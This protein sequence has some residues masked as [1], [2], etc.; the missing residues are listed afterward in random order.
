MCV[1]IFG[2]WIAAT[3]L[4]VAAFAVADD[5][6]DG[7]Y[8]ND[9]SA[10]SFESFE[11]SGVDPAANG[12]GN[13]SYL[14]PLLAGFYPDPS[15]CR[16]GGDYYL[17]NSTFA[18]FPGIPIFHSTDLVNW[19]QLGHVIDR[20]E[21][22][23]Y[24]WVGVSGGIFAP[25][26][27]HHDGTFYVVCTMVGGEGNFVVTATDSAGPWSDATPLRFEG[28]D[29][30]LFFDDDG[31]AWIVNNGAPEGRP[32][33]EGH[34][35]IWL[36]EF[37][38]VAKR[39]VGPRKVLVNGGVD[40]S[41]QPIWI[42]GPHIFKREGSYYLCC[43]EGGTG[44][45]HSQVVFRSRHV[46][47]PYE[48]WDKNPILT[49]RDLSPSEAGAVTCTG[50]ADLE[51]GPDGQWWAVFLGVRPYEGRFS[52][53]GRE[54]FLLPVTWT[55]DGWP[56]ILPPGERVPLVAKSPVGAVVRPSE[57]APLNGTF[58]WRDE[59][60]GEALSPQW[61]MLREAREHWWAL[62]GSAGQ[63]K[64]MPRADTLSGSGNPSYLARRIQHARF[65]ASLVV[66]PPQQ[67]G[68]SAGLAVFQNERNYYFLSVRREGGKLRIELERA[69]RQRSEVIAS[70][71]LPTTP[72]LKLCIEANDATCSIGFIDARG[73][74]ISLVADTDAR[75]LTTEVAGGFVG[76]TM[77]PHARLDK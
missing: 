7:T 52:P 9:P 8:T 30:S 37:D 4:G 65:K 38:P 74:L 27:T 75:V 3:G 53:M 24:D 6:G 12:V 16:V 57:E 33:Y 10:V 64:L 48:P 44:P 76:A 1:N 40:L 26:I 47:G 72:K 68:I 34:R 56:L 42:E 29:P 60:E 46:E 70:A 49:Q 66:E 23:R 28:I 13:G 45:Q 15:L 25:A 69:D 73:M 14:N 61:I 17:I 32:L 67:P 39:M 54:T 41:K 36:Q 63:L 71:S 21:L 51:I 77:G 22:L 59:F 20:P 31:R 18:Y 11:Y 2:A 55:D 5:N 50:H 19:R 58:T 62:D 43:A 35:A